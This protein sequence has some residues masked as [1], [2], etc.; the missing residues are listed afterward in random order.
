M[1]GE[2]RWRTWAG[3]SVFLLLQ[4]VVLRFFWMARFPASAATLAVRSVSPTS[5]TTTAS[6][7]PPSSGS[8]SSASL[9]RSELVGSTVDPHPR[10]CEVWD[11]AQSHAELIASGTVHFEWM[12]PWSQRLA[13]AAARQPA[14]YCVPSLYLVGMPKTGTTTLYDWLL[15]HPQLRAAQFKEPGFWNNPQFGPQFAARD[16]FRLL[17]PIGPAN[18]TNTP[19]T[20]AVWRNRPRSHPTTTAAA[21]AEAAA[22]SSAWFSNQQLTDVAPEWYPADPPG[23]LRRMP[24]FHAHLNLPHHQID[25]SVTYAIC[26]HVARR[27]RRAVPNARVLLVVRE[28]VARFVSHYRMLRFNAG[29]YELRSAAQ[30]VRDNLETVR[31]CERRFSDTDERWRWCLGD[32]AV[33]CWWSGTHYDPAPRAANYFIHGLYDRVYDSWVQPHGPFPPE[34]VLVLSAE[35][36][37]RDP[38]ATVIR[39]WRF[40]GLYTPPD[41]THW[42]LTFPHTSV[43]AFRSKP[44]FSSPE[45]RLECTLNLTRAYDQSMRRFAQQ[46]GI[47]Y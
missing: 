41:V 32:E 34:Q 31:R 20:R 16:F 39:I 5:T 6:S 30:A 47:V 7:S 1:S 15:Q 19:L 40:Y 9:G 10:Y 11:G 26:P 46:T 18:A 4:L 37:W 42:N 45:E 3:L 29:D 17:G 25:A 2:L 44:I 35:S 23:T 12:W 14:V 8:S 22:D 27:L 21:A 28:P 24:E 33:V 13:P 38:L 36:M 43:T